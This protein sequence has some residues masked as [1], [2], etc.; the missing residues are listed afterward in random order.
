MVSFQVYRTI[1]RRSGILVHL[2]LN[3]VAQYQTMWKFLVVT[4]MEKG[5]AVKSAQ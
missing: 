1:Q 2:L 4:L 3:N 5:F